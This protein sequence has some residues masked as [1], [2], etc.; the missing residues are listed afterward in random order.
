MPNKWEIFKSPLIL[1]QFIVIVILILSKSC[2][3]VN[4]DIP[5][6]YDKIDKPEVI[7]TNIVKETTHKTDTIYRWKEKVVTSVPQIV[8]I[9][10]SPFMDLSD[11][12]EFFT[13]SPGTFYYGKKEKDINYTIR[14][15]SQCRPDS[16]N[17][18]YAINQMIINDSV[19]EK[20]TITQKVRVNQ[21]YFGG[22]VVVYPNFNSVY[23]GVD[24]VSKKG[25]QI[26]G[27]VGLNVNE[28]QPQVKVG[29][30][31]LITFRGK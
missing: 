10:S 9:H 22:E 21:I 15:S 28:L 6:I 30:K 24:F 29:L 1:L 31:K 26:E 13:N 14:V 25:W 3:D 8:Y 2:G 7:S 11:T 12:N 17:M 20:T 18:E 23:A 19:L 5:K 4:I 27:A 16:V